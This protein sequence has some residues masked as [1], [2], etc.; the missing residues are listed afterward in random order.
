MDT[1]INLLHRIHPDASIFQN[2]ALRI[3]VHNCTCLELFVL[4]S[5]L[6]E[7]LLTADAFLSCLEI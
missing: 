1:E 6:S 2:V 4:C 7:Q 5:G 3:M